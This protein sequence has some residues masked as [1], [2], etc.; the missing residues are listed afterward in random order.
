MYAF[1]FSIALVFICRMTCRIL[2]LVFCLF[3]DNNRHM[4]TCLCIWLAELLESHSVADNIEWCCFP[5]HHFSTSSIMHDARY[6]AIYIHV[7][8]RIERAWN[9]ALC[10]RVLGIWGASG[11][12]CWPLLCI[13]EMLMST[14]LIRHRTFRIGIYHLSLKLKPFFLFNTRSG[15]Q[16]LQFQFDYFIYTFH[17][18]IFFSFL[19]K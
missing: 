14:F 4:Y 18:F 7:K 11:D 16:I 5:M 15:I 6:I 2:C 1:G 9:N 12:T 8:W 3:F 17:V 13:V 10:G 19:S